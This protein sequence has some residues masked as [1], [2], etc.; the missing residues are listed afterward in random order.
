MTPCEQTDACENIAFPQLLVGRCCNSIALDLS[1]LWSHW[2]PCFKVSV[3]SLT[4][5]LHYRRQRSSGKVMFLQ[6]SVILS[7]VGGAWSRGG[8]CSQGDAWSRGVCSG[9]GAWSGGSAPR[10]VLGPRGVPGGDPP[11]TA[12]AASGTHPT[13]MHS[14]CLCVSFFE[15]ECKSNSVV[16]FSCPEPFYS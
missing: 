7:T 1:S 15:A 8:V 13:G 16:N 2:Y 9:G 12:T 4:C 14:C 5:V 6:A 10:G 3:D 11:G